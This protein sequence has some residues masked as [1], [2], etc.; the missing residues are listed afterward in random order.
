MMF[1]KLKYNYHQN[2]KYNQIKHDVINY[3]KTVDKYGINGQINDNRTVS[4]YLRQDNVFI[5]DSESNTIVTYYKVSYGMP[6][7]LDTQLRDSLIKALDRSKKDSDKIKTQ[8]G[9]S[10]KKN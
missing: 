8:A 6:Y 5:F 10:K 2:K 4:Y 1:K 9:I 7:D 3:C